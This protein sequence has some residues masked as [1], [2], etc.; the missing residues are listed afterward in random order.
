MSKKANCANTEKKATVLY[1]YV[2]T[3]DYGSAPCVD[4]DMLT[5]ALCKGGKRGGMRLSAAKEVLAG[6]DVYVIGVYGKSLW[7]NPIAGAEY[8][9]VY[10]AKLDD[11]VPMTQYFAE[12]GQARGRKDDC[13]TVVNGTL[14][15][16]VKHDAATIENDIG[17]KYVLT[18]HRFVYWGDK[19]GD[20]RGREVEKQLG[21]RELFNKSPRSYS[22]DRNAAKLLQLTAKWDWFPK[23]DRAVKLGAPINRER[24]KDKCAPDETCD[25]K[26]ERKIG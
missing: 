26:P 3:H 14:V 17:G 10:M 19:C 23:T 7:G 15:C 6:N 21:L 11:A 1:A 9:P 24:S 22:V 25:K 20:A 18:S 5:L 4:G 12:N 16:T 2:M 13:Y 8:M